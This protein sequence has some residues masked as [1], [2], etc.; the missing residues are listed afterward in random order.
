VRPFAG[1]LLLLLLLLGGCATAPVSDT[2]AVVSPAA[3]SIPQYKLWQ[4]RGRV[5]LVR[6]EQGWHASLDWRETGGRY[7]LRLSG[8][9]GQGA[10]Q[11]D[12][13]GASVQLQTAD[14]REYR[15][16]DA[17]TLVEQATG[18][19]L[20]VAGIRY[21]VRGIPAPGVE[22]RITTD[23]QGRLQHLQQS[24]WDI[25]Y[26]R[27]E[28]VDGRDWPTRLRLNTAD[29]AI[30]MV[31]DQWTLSNSPEEATAGPVPASRIP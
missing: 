31:V 4:F 2:G 28:E 1:F 6:G 20:P 11:V 8:P 10:L 14:G 9:L 24:G 12:G 13:N 26:E 18:W 29:I 5:S 7:R 15:A 3:L 30:R 17:D 25:R 23:Q 16:P 19:Q 27:Y 21:W 22:A